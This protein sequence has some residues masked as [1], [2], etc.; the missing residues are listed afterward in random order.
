MQKHG[1]QH[2]SAVDEQFTA[3]TTGLPEAVGT[4]VID[5]ADGDTTSATT[6][7]TRRRRPFRS[8]GRSLTGSSSPTP[9]STGTTRTSART[10]DR[11]WAYTGTSS[12]SQRTRITVRPHT[13]S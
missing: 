9:A 13:A 10:T 6:G 4:Q 5:L 2:H 12:S 8:V 3:D 11:R 7:H 1:H